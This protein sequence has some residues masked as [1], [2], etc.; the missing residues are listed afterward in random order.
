MKAV[1]FFILVCAVFLAIG[2]VYA[3]GDE[4]HGSDANVAAS[5]EPSQ[6]APGM[7]GMQSASGQSAEAGHGSD[8]HDDA[9]GGHESASEGDF[10]T[11]LKKLHPAT[12]HFPIAL[13]LMAALAELFVMAGRGA[14]AEPAVRVLIYGGAA[15][16]VVAALFGWIHTGVWFG[17][18]TVM[19]LHRWNGMLIT[20][21][22]L[23]LAGLAYRPREGRA[24]LRSGLFVMGALI[25]L[26]G[27]LGGELA[28]GPDHLGLSWT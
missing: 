1:H 25:L 15:G 10:V 27:F 22:G 21:L 18:D 3:H 19:Q 8:E 17:G 26:Q 4:A 5:S 13:F 24:L 9:S 11:V 2:P 6:E 16:A 7:N 20:A 14:A 28:H 12:I 23:A